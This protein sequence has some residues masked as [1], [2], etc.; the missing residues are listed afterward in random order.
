MDDTEQAIYRKQRGV[1]GLE[2]FAVAR[3]AD[4]ITSHAGHDYIQPKRGTL[5]ATLLQVYRAYPA[6][7]TDREAAELANLDGAWKRCSDLRRAGLIAPTGETRGTPAGMVC[8]P[9]A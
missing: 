5:A 6:G 8:R 2:L 3:D 4:P 1:E 9:T 7:L